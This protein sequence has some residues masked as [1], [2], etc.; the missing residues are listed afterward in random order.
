MPS[1]TISFTEIGMSGWRSRD[2]GP[3]TDTSSQVFPGVAIARFASWAAKAALANGPSPA[4]NN[5]AHAADRKLRRL[6]PAS[7]GFLRDCFI[8]APPMFCDCF[9]DYA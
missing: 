1:S 7:A 9:A 5:G 3:F 2:Q 4:A 6:I 8:I